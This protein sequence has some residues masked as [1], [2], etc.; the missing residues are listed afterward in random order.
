MKRYHGLFRVIWST[1]NYNVK[2]PFGKIWSTMALELK[3]I[4]HAIDVL[5]VRN[6]SKLLYAPALLTN[7]N[8]CHALLESLEMT[9]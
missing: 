3:P 6:I 9:P 4:K 2:V 8:I 7:L 1:Q 5:N